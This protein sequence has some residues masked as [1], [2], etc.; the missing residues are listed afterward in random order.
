[1]DALAQVHADA[2]EMVGAWSPDDL[3]YYQAADAFLSWAMSCR[4]V[5]VL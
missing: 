2:D 3:G 1:M 5:V 4:P